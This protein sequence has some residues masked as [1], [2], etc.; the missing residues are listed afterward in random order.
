M[1]FTTFSRI[2][3]FTEVV[4]MVASSALR[5]TVLLVVSSASGAKG[6]M[7]VTTY[8]HFTLFSI[9]GDDQHNLGWPALLW[10]WHW[11][12]QSGSWTWPAP[13]RWWAAIMINAKFWQQFPRYCFQNKIDWTWMTLIEHWRLDDGGYGAHLSKSRA[14][15][16]LRTQFAVLDFHSKNTVRRSCRQYMTYDGGFTLSL[17][18]GSCLSKQWSQDQS[19]LYPKEWG[20]SCAVSVDLGWPHCLLVIGRLM[21]ND[22]RT[23][24][25]C[26]FN[27]GWTMMGNCLVA[28]VTQALIKCSWKLLSFY[29]SSSTRFW[30]PWG[31]A[32][33]LVLVTTPI[34][35]RGMAMSCNLW[36]LL[37]W[38]LADWTASM[39][40]T[41]KTSRKG[42][43][44]VWQHPEARDGDRHSSYLGELHETC[45]GCRLVS[46]GWPVA[47]TLWLSVAFPVLVLQCLSEVWLSSLSMMV[48]RCSKHR[49]YSSEVVMNPEEE[50]SR[51]EYALLR[52]ALSLLDD[53]IFQFNFTFNSQGGN[54]YLKGVGM[55]KNVPLKMATLR[56]QTVLR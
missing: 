42:C 28:D 43:W 55:V 3:E 52:I 48:A 45:L 27:R 40:G 51:F 30:D 33:P 26:Q 7:L 36:T 17:N 31:R 34:S 4:R 12:R 16:T 35:F 1:I 11:W 47:A 5:G 41:A 15:R 2:Q 56:W 44:L 29:V 39:L 49:V 19:V 14:C 46:Q 37:C 32:G 6:T 54:Y 13:W 20:V 25:H 9:H 21:V 38:T 22:W 23:L 50:G 18:E 53:D 8:F 24:K 10:L